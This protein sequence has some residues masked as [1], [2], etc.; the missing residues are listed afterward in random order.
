MHLRERQCHAAIRRTKVLPP[1]ALQLQ[2]AGH[3][4]RTGQGHEGAYQSV[5]DRYG[6][7]TVMF[8]VP[9]SLPATYYNTKTLHCTLSICPLPHLTLKFCPCT[10]ATS[11]A[12][13]I[14]V[15]P[16][17]RP[18]TRQISSM[19]CPCDYLTCLTTLSTDCTMKTPTTKTT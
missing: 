18:A 15:E 6:R 4:H 7:I 14:S 5:H 9:A 12:P 2:N 16:L 19:S 13:P 10:T 3:L 17:R 11:P 8:G 1:Q